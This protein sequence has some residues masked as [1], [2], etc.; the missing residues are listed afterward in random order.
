MIRVDTRARAAG[1]RLF[2][3][4]AVTLVAGASLVRVEMDGSQDLASRG[5]VAPARRARTS[6]R[7]SVS[8][9]KAS[10]TTKIA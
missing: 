5:R 7:P 10:T 9:W 4:A 1:V 8:I 3:L 2:C 6:W